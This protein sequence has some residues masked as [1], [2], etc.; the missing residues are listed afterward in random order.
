MKIERAVIF[1][2]TSAIA[3][4]FGR[5][6]AAR[7]ARLHLVGRDEAKL[8]ATRDDLLARGAAQVTTAVVD[9]NLASE[10]ARLV[11]EAAAALGSLDAALV[12]QGTLSDQ[13][14]CA[15]DAALAQMEL[16]TNFVAPASLLAQLALHFES[17]GRGAIVVIG[18]VAGDR[19]RASN[20]VYGSAKAGL[21]AFASGLRARLREKGVAVLTVKPGFVDTPMTA[22]FAKGPLWAQPDDVGRG[23]LRATEAGRT[24]VYL[25]GFWGV[26][27]FVIRHLPEWV[28][29]RMKF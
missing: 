27:M 11:A 21:A 4:G 25:P 2:A 7:G 19:G 3:A 24:V 23:I 10:H 9:L 16:T 26:I 22:A 17:Q 15:R 8:A 20:Y 6:L 12:A 14:R 28:F 18:S 5:A 1:G 13:E 29:L